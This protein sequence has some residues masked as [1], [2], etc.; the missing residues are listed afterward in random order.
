[1]NIID[2]DYFEIDEKFRNKGFGKLLVKKLVDLYHPTTIVA[3]VLS[4]Q[5]YKSLYKVLGEPYSYSF[6][7]DTNDYENH[8]KYLPNDANE[9]EKT[10][11]NKD[12]N[13]MWD[14]TN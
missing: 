1:M 11:K 14:L 3:D 13:Y 5:S 6:N 12:I 7:N 9:W 8:F 4:K 2:I 10:G